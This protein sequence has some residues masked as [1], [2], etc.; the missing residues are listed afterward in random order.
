MFGKSRLFLQRI[1]N[2][3]TGTRNGQLAA[4]PICGNCASSISQVERNKKL[5]HMQFNPEP[6]RGSLEIPPPPN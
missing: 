2:K 5:Q 6:A 4:P 1:E 3:T